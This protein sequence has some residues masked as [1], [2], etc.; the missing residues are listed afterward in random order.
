MG[1]DIFVDHG[2]ALEQRVFG[3]EFP[4]FFSMPSCN[5]FHRDDDVRPAAA[6]HQVDVRITDGLLSEVVAQHMYY[7][8]GIR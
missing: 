3:N 7:D 8:W 2:Y 4:D 6:K 1:I 5:R